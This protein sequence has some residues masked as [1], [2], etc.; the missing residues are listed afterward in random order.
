MS[1]FKFFSVFKWEFRK[2]WDVLAT[3]FARAFSPADN[4]RRGVRVT[5]RQVQGVGW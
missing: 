3:A 4:V 1:A 5:V 2:G